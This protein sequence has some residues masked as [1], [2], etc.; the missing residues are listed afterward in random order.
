MCVYLHMY[1]YIWTVQS[2]IVEY[3]NYEIEYKFNHVSY[4]LTTCMM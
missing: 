1:L 4:K 3:F 2:S